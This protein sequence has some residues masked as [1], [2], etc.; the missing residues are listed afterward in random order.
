MSTRNRG[1]VPCSVE[2]CRYPTR[3][4]R[5]IANQYPFPTRGRRKGMCHVCHY[6]TL[7]KPVPG[8]P[9]VT[10]DP[11]DPPNPATI[12][13]HNA[14]LAGRHAREARAARRMAATNP[15]STR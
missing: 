6:A 11:N 14:F 4:H 10:V 3:P 1:I 15:R 8:P 9:R 2:T 5:S 7:P 13:A 12:A